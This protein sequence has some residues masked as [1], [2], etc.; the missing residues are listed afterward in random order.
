MADSFIERRIVT[1]LIVSTEYV[2]Q[3]RSVWSSKMLEA[4]TA[5]NLANWCVDFFDEFHKA[6]GIEIESIFRRKKKKMGEEERED[7]ADLLSTLSDDYERADKFNVD[8]LL[9][10]TIEYFE[11]R[12]LTDL[13]DGIRNQLEEGNITEAK[14]L[15]S[16]HKSV[17][18][19]SDKDIDLA[20]PEI[21]DA[22]EK[23]FEVGSNPLI[24]YPRQL[25]EFWNDQL[26]RGAFVA[27]MAPEKRGKTYWLLD[28]AMRAAKQRSNVAFFQAGDMDQ[29]QQIRRMCIYL[30]KRNNK[31][32]YC[33][34]HFEPVRDCKLNQLDKCTLKARESD[35]GVFDDKDEEYLKKGITFEELVER[36]EEN[37]E[38]TPCWNCSSYWKRHKQYGVVW[39]KKIKKVNS[40]SVEEGK[41]VIDDFFVKQN[42]RFKL[43]TYAN[44]TLTVTEI[45]RTL[46][47]WERRDGFVADVIIVDYI[48]IMASEL[49]GEFRHQENDKWMN[50]R[51]LSQ[52]R[53]ALVI[54]VTQTD[55][56]SYEQ[57][58]LALKNFSEDKRKFGHVTAM[59]GLN[60][61]KKGR[62]KKMGVMRINEIM[63]REGS[64]SSNNEVHVLQN[65]SRGIP[66]ISSFW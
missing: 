66:F 15:A 51:G 5:Q 41:K 43:S 33:K 56:K 27:L 1:G 28:L 13:V 11:E 35:F 10:Q 18:T 40:L 8:Y 32:K 36:W 52:K 3:I 14:T 49:R 44:K 25:G 61:D 45:E 54:S 21:L 37:P 62:E 24:E 29:P 6:P 16:E 12:E 50:M 34:E 65:L 58:R 17:I 42:R 9:K 23:A 2:Q 64:F 30:A 38:Y 20:S 55:A 60:Q 19:I 4:R 7:I 46:D 26:V 57:D 39:L 48:D 47:L 31:E 53:N 63:I 59:Y 22:V